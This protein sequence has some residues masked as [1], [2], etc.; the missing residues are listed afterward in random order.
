MLHNLARV[1]LLPTHPASP[2]P[3]FSPVYLIIIILLLDMITPRF[4]ILG[5]IMMLALL[6]VVSATTT[7]TTT[8]TSSSL[9]TTQP[10][11]YKTHP[12]SHHQQ[13]PHADRQQQELTGLP[14]QYQQVPMTTESTTLEFQGHFLCSPDTP[15]LTDWSFTWKAF[16]ADPTWHVE[17]V[18]V[19]IYDSTTYNM[20]TF[21]LQGEDAVNFHIDY[22]WRESLEESINDSITI[23]G[24]VTF[25]KP[26]PIDADV[27]TYQSLL[28]LQPSATRRYNY[29]ISPG[30]VSSSFSK[31]EDTLWHLTD[32]IYNHIPNPTA[33]HDPMPSPYSFVT[34]HFVFA[35]PF[36]QGTVSTEGQVFDQMR[37]HT[38][39][40]FKWLDSYSIEHYLNPD[41][42]HEPTT[43]LCY[44]NNIPVD[45]YIESGSQQQ[46]LILSITPAVY[47]EVFY[48]LFSTLHTFPT[49]TLDVHCGNNYFIYDHHQ[50]INTTTT[51]TTF[52]PTPQLAVSF[53]QMQQQSQLDATHSVV[54]IST[55]G[56]TAWVPIT[57]ITPSNSVGWSWLRMAD[58]IILDEAWVH[59]GARQFWNPLPNV[60][61]SQSDVIYNVG[62]TATTH[63]DN[64]DD[65]DNTNNNNTTSTSKDHWVKCTFQFEPQLFPAQ[66]S[67]QLAVKPS[68][69][70][71]FYEH[72]I[73]TPVAAE[74]I[75][76][77]KQMFLFIEPTTEQFHDNAVNHTY[78]LHHKFAP[79]KIT[80]TKTPNP[81]TT[82]MSMVELTL[83]REFDYYVVPYALDYEEH[84]I[85][86]YFPLNATTT[87]GNIYPESIRCGLEVSYLWKNHHNETTNSTL[88][89]LQQQ[90]LNIDPHHDDYIMQRFALQQQLQTILPYQLN[91]N[92]QQFANF[93]FTKSSA[94]QFSFF[95]HNTTALNT[96]STMT[97]HTIRGL[98][99]FIDVGTQQINN[100]TVCDLKVFAI[101][102]SDHP[103][104]TTSLRLAENNTTA[105]LV[106]N[107]TIPLGNIQDDGKIDLTALT[108]DLSEAT[109]NATAAEDI[110]DLHRLDIHCRGIQHHKNTVVQL[111]SLATQGY[112]TSSADF[113]AVIEDNI[114]VSTLHTDP[115]TGAF[116][117]HE[118]YNN[119]KHPYQFGADG[120]TAL[121]MVIACSVIFGVG[122]LFGILYCCC[123]ANSKKQNNNN[124]NNHQNG[125][126]YPIARPTHA[127]QQQDNGFYIPPNSPRPPQL[128]VGVN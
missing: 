22:Q 111:G 34:P 39:G 121:A 117:L 17:R 109:Y 9:I 69:S 50:P 120:S 38:F 33:D 91:Q 76:V 27:A 79:T 102:P 70:F 66:R 23:H 3:Y 118:Q 13:Q 12:R 88:L 63:D 54:E 5:V 81:T 98:H 127:N 74:D 106:Y 126:D 116:L 100:K 26:F 83:A 40:F 93:S 61:P 119:I 84:L 31:V 43:P 105:T 16:A 96:L 62:A 94:L 73:T 58:H 18:D 49:T 36:Q 47:R 42:P 114:L 123:R 53:M 90:D 20:T 57:T 45:A 103:D 99:R 122:C 101:S 80:T 55:E 41:A 78:S 35:Q 15:C 56:P 32:S 104:N 29:Q 108:F 110:A 82:M 72:N 107:T 11:Q 52:H 86:T 128:G 71:A 89:S 113:F 64:E 124:N 44:V 68:L 87:V 2:S 59:A 125:G 28:I 6:F 4:I 48:P 65:N 115:T 46:S 37:L 95:M 21:V 30:V 7:T 92:E 25:N 75:F 14:F 97:L 10:I 67:Y 24:V 19:H 112:M 8:T 60:M 1:L 51:T 85:T 77:A